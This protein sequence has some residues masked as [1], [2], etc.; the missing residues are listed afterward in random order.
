MVLNRGRS[1][2]PTKSPAKPECTQ[3]QMAMQQTSTADNGSDGTVRW[4]MARFAMGARLTVQANRLAIG[5]VMPFMVADVNLSASE[6]GSVLSAFASGYAITQFPGGL[7]ADRIGSK[8]PLLVALVAVSLGSMIMPS[9]ADHSG[10]RGL[11]L[12]YFLMGL[13]E[14]PSYPSVGAMIGKWFPTTEK[15]RRAEAQR[16][17]WGSGSAT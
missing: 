17:S 2:S 15:V 9:A 10:C 3:T 5:A 12:V 6:K 8:L 13:F 14:G 7:A 1:A 16:G 11:C 4:S